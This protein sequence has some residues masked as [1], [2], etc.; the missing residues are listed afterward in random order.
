MDF[1]T[2]VRMAYLGLTLLNFISIFFV[3]YKKRRQATTEEEK[4][5]IDD[6]IRANFSTALANLKTNLSQ[7][8]LRYDAR[9]TKKVFDKL[10]KEDT[11]SGGKKGNQELEQR[12]ESI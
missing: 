1:D 5:Q 2:I 8:S 10:I 4:S 3:L 11:K 7:L 9:N 12:Q 6:V